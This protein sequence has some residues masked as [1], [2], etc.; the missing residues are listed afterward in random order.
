MNLDAIHASLIDSRTKGVPANTPPF[1]LDAIAQKG[2]N[3]LREDMNLPLAVL[4]QSGLAHNSAWMRDFIA[5][6]G[7]VIA[8]H[9]KT[10][11]APQLFQMQLD[12]GAWAITI[13]NPHQM[14]V[15]RAH[16]VQRIILANQ[17]IGRQGLRYILSELRDHPDFEFFAIVDSAAAVAQWE[18]GLAEIDPGRPVQLL[19]EGGMKGGRT[20]VRDIATGL[21]VA[22]RVAAHPRLALRGVEGF[23]GLVVGPR[24]EREA[25][26]RSFLDLLVGLAKAC[27][28][29]GLFAPHPE[30]GGEVLLTAGGSAYYDMVLACFRHAGLTRPT[31]I[32]T[33]SGCYLSHDA[34]SYRRFFSEISERSGAAGGLVSAIEVWGYVQSRPEPDRVLCTLGARDISGGDPPLPQ[35]WF[36]PGMNAPAALPA[37]HHAT[38]MNDQH[39]YVAVPEDSPLAV[40]D[41]VSFGVS[42]PCLT[43][44]K[45]DVIPVVDD[46]Y[47]VVGAV[48]T[49][50]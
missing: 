24:E 9:G 45:W 18:A 35:T 41:M 5:R 47:N 36:R 38:G 21:A 1:R 49:F 30:S 19:L 7:A 20:G 28:A 26:V 32:I 27:E 34:I 17:V 4:K 22:R 3:V 42:H 12:D 44:D 37:G 11:M 16:G 29:E 13:A 14:Q 10:T 50:F 15:A 46:A 25:Q 43:F 40:G 23:E 48:R 31:R 6:S 2:W 8:P 33:R 39:C